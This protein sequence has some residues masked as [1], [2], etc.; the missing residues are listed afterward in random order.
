MLKL[1]ALALI[2]SALALV[3]ATGTGVRGAGT[4]SGKLRIDSSDEPFVIFAPSPPKPDAIA[5]YDLPDGADDYH[6]LFAPDAP[7]LTAAEH[8]DVFAISSWFV[9]Y[10]ATDDELRALIAGLDERGIALGLEMEPLTWPGPEVCDHT[11]GF[12]GPWDLEMAQK[13]KDLGGTVRLVSLDEPYANAHKLSGPGACAYPVEQVVDEVRDFIRRLRLIFPDVVVGSIEPLVTFP[14]MEA[15][16]FEIWLDTYEGRAG[17]PFAFI[18][19]DVEWRRQDWPQTV[20]EIEAVA[21]ARAVPFG[22]L[23]YGDEHA[24]TNEDFLAA[25]ADHAFVFEQQAGGTPDVVGFYAWHEQLDRVLPDDDLDAFT[26]RINQYFGVRTELTQPRIAA[27]GRAVTGRLTTEADEPLAGADIEIEATPLG[28]A[29]QRHRLSGTVPANARKAL[30]AIRANVEGGRPAVVNVRISDISYREGGK[31]KNLV[32]NPRFGKGLDSWGP[33]GDGDVRVMRGVGGAELAI[34][35]QPLQAAYVD[36]ATFRV[37][38]GAA[39][40]FSATLDV[41]RKSFDSGYVSLIFLG[42]EEESG[43][44][45]LWFAPR[46]IGLGSVTTGEDGGYRVATRSLGNGRYRLE[47]AYGG[48]LDHRPSR[49]Q[50]RITVK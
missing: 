12:E 9:R 49:T 28:R 18:N 26:G 37:K 34:R 25:V 46:P 41:P 47:L 15:R 7:W 4:D 48:D 24:Q 11:E 27:E 21:D 40:D 8:V 39:F 50:A 32:P 33:Y 35:A 10:Y 5:H 17:E 3:V 2:G 30:V 29:R 44:R 22:I 1:R 43:R 36:G 19:V 31:R 20:R 13:L 6:E 38:P 42:G 45:N 14:R 23:Y 16:D